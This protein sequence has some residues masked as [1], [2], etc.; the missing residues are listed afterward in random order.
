[1]PELKID[2]QSE[3]R[4]HKRFGTMLEIHRSYGLCIFA[5]IRKA[6][7]QAK[8]GISPRRFEF[9]SISHLLGGRGLLWTPKGGIRTYRPGQ[10]VFIVPEMV[11]DYG[12]DNSYFVEDAICFYGP[13]ADALRDSGIFQPG[14]FEMGMIRRLQPIFDLV[15]TPVPDAQIK[16]NMLLQQLIVDV[17]FENKERNLPRKTSMQRLLDLIAAGPERLWTIRE[18]AEIYG[19]SESQFRRV[20][21]RETGF[22]PKTYVD[23]YKMRHAAELLLSSHASIRQI[24]S[25]LAYN[26]PYHFSRRFKQIM[27]MAPERYRERMSLSGSRLDPSP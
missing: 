23:N 11:N 16:A 19:Q 2:S 4:V 20:F 25:G 24:A 22:Y 17:Y 10:G 3:V 1:M 15:T 12:G 18:M 21:K 14:I 27:G 13:V 8:Q 26:D 9:Y 5:F 6:R 7:Y